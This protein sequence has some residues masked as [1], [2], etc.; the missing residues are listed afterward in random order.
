[1]A[2]SFVPL[3]AETDQD[4]ARYLEGKLAEVACLDC[5]ARVKVRKNSDFHTS[6]QW[7][8]AARLACAEFNR[9]DARDRIRPV[10]ESCSRLKA[11]IARAVQDGDLEVGADVD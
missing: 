10:H 1:M 9:A 5:L 11:S 7:D 8:A 6:I 2:S 3:H 4:K